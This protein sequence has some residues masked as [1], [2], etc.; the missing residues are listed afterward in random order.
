MEDFILSTCS[1]DEIQAINLAF[2]HKKQLAREGITNPLNSR[3]RC[4]CHIRWNHSKYSFRNRNYLIPMGGSLVVNVAYTPGEV[5]DDNGEV[6]IVSDDPDTPT[7]MV[8]LQ[9]RGFDPRPP[10]IGPEAIARRA[11]KMDGFVTPPACRSRTE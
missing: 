4:P 8:S 9:G 3:S 2:K 6:H 10:D 1:D 5:G 7:V 11:G